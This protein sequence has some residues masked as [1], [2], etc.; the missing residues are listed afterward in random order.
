MTRPRLSG[1]RLAALRRRM[2][3]AAGHRCSECGGG[4]GKLELHHVKEVRDG[5]DDSD[6]NIL[7]LCFHHHRALHAGARTPGSDAW[8]RLLA[9]STRED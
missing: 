2:L 4:A 5:G 7:V 3:D 1:R 8:D 9:D 6:G